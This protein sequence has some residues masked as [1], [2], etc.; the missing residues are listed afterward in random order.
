MSELQRGARPGALRC[1]CLAPI[2]VLLALAILHGGARPLAIESTTTCEAANP[3]DELPDDEALQACLDNYDQVL[4]KPDNLRGYV[5]YIIGD[6]IKLKHDHILLTTAESPHK[7]TLV[8]A[9]SL[10]VPLLRA[11]TS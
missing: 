11:S 9:P 3:F 10:N 8:A 4:L 5:G 2:A 7:V 6:T 1:R